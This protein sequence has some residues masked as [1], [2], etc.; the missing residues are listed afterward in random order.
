MWQ[1]PRFRWSSQSK[2]ASSKKMM[3]VSKD[4]VIPSTYAAPLGHTIDD[5][6]ANLSPHVDDISL[7]RG[8][9][10]VPYRCYP[11]TLVR[12]RSLRPCCPSFVWIYCSSP[13]YPGVCRCRRCSIPKSSRRSI[14]DRPMP[15]RIC[16][17][18]QPWIWPLFVSPWFNSRPLTKS[19]DGSSVKPSGHITV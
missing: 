6:V 13:R 1:R 2:M 15:P 19:N 14:R 5:N 10:T 3:Y 8:H 4:A 7:F 17:R 9:R 16:W 12:R 18:R 11:G